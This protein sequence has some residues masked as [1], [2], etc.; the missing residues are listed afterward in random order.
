MTFIITRTD[1]YKVHFFIRSHETPHSP[2]SVAP[3]FSIP[4]SVTFIAPFAPRQGILAKAPPPKTL[5]SHH[6]HR[7]IHILNNLDT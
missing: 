1:S 6:H 2:S 4:P 3:S 7:T 5:P